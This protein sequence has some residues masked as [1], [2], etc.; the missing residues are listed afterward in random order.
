MTDR[1]LFAVLSVGL[2]LSSCGDSVE[3]RDARR[4]I[5][6]AADATRDLVVATW[7][8][9]A[10][11]AEPQ[12]EELRVRLAELREAAARRGDAALAEVRPALAEA[13]RKLE[14]IGDE[15][16][17]AKDRSAESLDAAWQNIRERLNAA[18]RTLDDADGEL[19]PPAPLP[20]DPAPR[21]GDG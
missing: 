10:E 15:I 19:D 9:L 17:A 5:E 18:R 7:N 11:R 8:D 6:E 1:A 12:L 14:Q 20:G 2:L 21:E 13:E 16:A 3:A 4:E